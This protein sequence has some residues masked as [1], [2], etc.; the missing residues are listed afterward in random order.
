M[1]S[2]RTA[3][4]QCILDKV[5]A[6]GPEKTI[7]PSEVARELGGEDWRSLMPLIRSIG[8]ELVESGDIQVTQQGKIVD[9][10]DVKTPF[11]L[12]YGKSHERW[13]RVYQKT[14]VILLNFLQGLIYKS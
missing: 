1:S 4:C 6:R 9:P 3:I 10:L 5:R 2:D 12:G 7:C 13:M 8:A 14:E 11:A